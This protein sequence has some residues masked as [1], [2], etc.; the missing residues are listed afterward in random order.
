MQHA[1]EVL[2][3]FFKVLLVTVELAAIS[4]TCTEHKMMIDDK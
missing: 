4:V 3:V 1:A 2:N